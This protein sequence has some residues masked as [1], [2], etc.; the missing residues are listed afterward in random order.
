MDIDNSDYERGHRAGQR[1]WE[2]RAKGETYGRPAQPGDFTRGW[3]LGGRDREEHERLF[4]PYR[5][6]A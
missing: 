1:A 2:L 3:D 5:K 4:A 6:G